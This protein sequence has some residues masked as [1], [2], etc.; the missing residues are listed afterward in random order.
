MRYIV[1]ERG[2]PW[3]V[4][5]GPMGFWTHTYYRLFVRPWFS[6]RQKQH[7]WHWR[8]WDTQEQTWVSWS[9]SG[10]SMTM[11]FTHI[12]EAHEWCDILNDEE[13]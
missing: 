3:P 13:K 7:P 9:A 11:I 8:I 2:Q 12:N 10:D 6:R 4:I 1:Q 5:I